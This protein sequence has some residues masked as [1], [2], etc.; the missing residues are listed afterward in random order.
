MTLRPLALA[1]AACSQPA[2][3][4]A[5]AP[6]ASTQSANQRAAQLYADYWEASLALSPLNATFVGDTRFN[7]QLPG[8]TDGTRQ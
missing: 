7:D 3:D 2:T 8:I 4:T 5:T 6:Q 1:L